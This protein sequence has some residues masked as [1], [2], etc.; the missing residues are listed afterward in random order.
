MGDTTTEIRVAIGDHVHVA[1][2]HGRIHDALVTAVFGY[3]SKEDRNAAILASRDNRTA[4]Q[5]EEYLAAPFL[6]PSVN[7]IYVS[8]DPL[9]TDPYGRQVERLASLPHHSGTP[10]PGRYWEQ[11]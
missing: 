9:K 7:V 11:V 5:V 6:A 10:A 2:E 3:G 8:D 1:D 4:E